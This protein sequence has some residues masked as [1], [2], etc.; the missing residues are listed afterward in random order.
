MAAVFIMKTSNY[1]RKPRPERYVCSTPAFKTLKA[2]A[3]LRKMSLLF[4]SPIATEK[5]ITKARLP[6]KNE[7]K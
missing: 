2:D 4:K 1:L 7:N 5:G 6:Q 3:S